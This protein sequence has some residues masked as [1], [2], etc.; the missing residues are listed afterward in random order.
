MMDTVSLLDENYSTIKRDSRV[1]SNRLKTKPKSFQFILDH[2]NKFRLSR[3]KNKLEDMKDDL[4]FDSYTAGS[5]SRISSS[6]SKKIMRKSKKIAELEEKIMILSNENVPSNY[7]SRRAIKLRKNMMSNVR[8][9]TEG[10][11]SV[12]EENYDKVFGE[13]VSKV[14]GY[15]GDITKEAMESI[16]NVPAANNDIDLE[17]VSENRGNEIANEVNKALDVDTAVIEPTSNEGFVP[18]VSDME[19]VVENNSVDT[20]VRETVADVSQPIVEEPIS[21]QN[22]VD[23]RVNVE[24]GAVDEITLPEEISSSVDSVQENVTLVS[25]EDVA[26]VV[27]SAFN[28]VSIDNS[29]SKVE[30]VIPVVSQEEIEAEVG[31]ASDEKV[32]PDIETA[33]G[34]TIDYDVI[35]DEIDVAL[36]KIKIPQ[37]ENNEEKIDTFDSQIEKR[38]R[39][40]Y[41]PMTD[42]EIAEAREK[43]EYDKY[44]KIFADRWDELNSKKEEDNQIKQV[45]D[46]ESVRE[47]PVVVP[48][49]NEIQPVVDI[50]ENKESK[51][52]EIE[53][54][55]FADTSEE[56]LHFDY[57]DAT[58]EDVMKAISFETSGKGLEALK[59]RALKLKEEN[60]KSKAASDEAIR[61]QREI[62][63]KA[64]DAR[65][66]S[67]KK[68]EAY[69]EKYKKLEDYCA[70][71]ERDTEINLNSA[72][73]AMDDAETNRKFI[74]S[75]EA[76]MLDLDD[77]MSEIDSIISPEAKN[78][79]LGR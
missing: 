10:G 63:E 38:Q 14:E 12:P 41:T 77:M 69:E 36:N 43:I 3:A 68:R 39:Y 32:V 73:V 21:E 22:I 66:Q 64:L 72:K 42:E 5:D 4:A 18:V 20:E 56:G 58:E 57:S 35:K 2:W 1:S 28:E 70:A 8:Y 53:E 33:A 52:D 54:F 29:E 75:T 61:Q 27:N 34:E 65:R 19:A 67:E 9:N 7:V 11:Y 76:E 51:E 23:N 71:L 50:N 31:V 55:V 13:E 45:S 79:R 25:P 15:P 24:E 62:A 49:R 30:P 37:N 46:P 17:R 26:E 6:S 47:V 59:Q 74:E 48:E 78:V 16:N 60:Q 40:T 44:Q